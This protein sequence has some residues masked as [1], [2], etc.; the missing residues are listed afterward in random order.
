MRAST[1]RQAKGVSDRGRGRTDRAGPAPGDFGADRWARASGARAWI[2]IRD[3]GC[4]MK[5]GR[6]G[7]DRGGP[8]GYGRHCSSP[9][10]RGRWS[11]G[12]R[13]LGWLQGR[14]SWAERERMPR[15]TQWRGRGHESVGREGRTTGKR[16]RAGR[17]NSGEESRPRGGA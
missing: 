3:L 7:L 14:R 15:W 1:D 6:R 10:R 12:G 5:I 17:S 9:R 16:S 4:A 8:N 11:W 13:E 2:I